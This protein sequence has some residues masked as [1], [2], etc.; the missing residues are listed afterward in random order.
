[1]EFGSIM[2]NNGEIFDGKKIG[3][4]TEFI[5]N[6]FSEYGILLLRLLFCWY[7]PTHIIN[8]C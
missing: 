5:I 8:C 1:M 2:M 4:L 6:K 3:E 7:E